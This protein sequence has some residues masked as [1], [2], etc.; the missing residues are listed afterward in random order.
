MEW[1]S[2]SAWIHSCNAVSLRATI[3]ALVA[4]KFVFGGNGGKE[5]NALCRSGAFLIC[6]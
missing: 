5:D 4:N 1:E 2:H 3:S 6:K